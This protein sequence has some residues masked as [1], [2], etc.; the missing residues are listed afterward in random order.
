MKVIDIAEGYQVRMGLGQRW[1]KH[2][3]HGAISLYSTGYK[4]LNNKNLSEVTLGGRY[5]YKRNRQENMYVLA[6][7][8]RSL[9]IETTSNHIL[10]RC[11]WTKRYQDDFSFHCYLSAQAQKK[12]NQWSWGHLWYTEVRYNP[13]KIIQHQARLMLSTHTGP[14]AL[15]D[16]PYTISLPYGFPQAF[17]L[18]QVHLV[19]SLTIRWQKGIR[20]A[21]LHNS[22]I[23][24][25]DS[26]H[27]VHLQLELSLR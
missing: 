9:D 1:H 23:T 2:Y 16:Y 26:L 12:N 7:Y 3:I 6:R 10:I 17:S 24:K 13:W 4:D 15:L 22:K 27:R 11:K 20:I 18:G 5:E 19:N 21:I 25:E 8:R 14:D